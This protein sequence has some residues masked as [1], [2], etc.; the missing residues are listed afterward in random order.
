M[1]MVLVI[2]PMSNVSYG[3]SI[4]ENEKLKLLLEE[5]SQNNE[6]FYDFMSYTSIKKYK[7]SDN[8]YDLLMYYKDG[9]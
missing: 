5:L 3:L 8:N 1:A 6:Y 4:R 9:V 2:I 7:L